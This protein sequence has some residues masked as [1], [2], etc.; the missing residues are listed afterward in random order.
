MS[1][2]PAGF[3]SAD[4]VFVPAANAYA[5]VDKG[6]VLQGS[7]DV[8]QDVF[9]FF[10]VLS[11][12]SETDVVTGWKT[13]DDPDGSHS[14]ASSNGIQTGYECIF[15][16]GNESSQGLKLNYDFFKIQL[17]L[18]SVDNLA[19]YLS[20]VEL[21]DGWFLDMAL[22]NDGKPVLYLRPPYVMT[23]SPHNY[24]TVRFRLYFYSSS[25]IGLS[26]VSF[27]SYP[28]VEFGDFVTSGLPSTVEGQEQIKNAINDQYDTNSGQQDAITGDV[29]TAISGLE[30]IGLFSFL[31]DF[32]KQF[33]GV[34]SSGDDS[35]ALT[36]PGFSIS[37]DGEQ[38]TVW[39][40]HTFDFAT[41]E[42]P[43]A[44]LLSALRLGTSVVVIGALISYLFGLYEHIFAGGEQY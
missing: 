29:N 1:G 34:F 23:V 4:A 22:S 11:L 43:F 17:N 8:A 42:G 33:V 9:Y 30:N 6:S 32:S 38:L 26:S 41:M 40:A 13:Y 7:G 25:A 21:P 44:V 16:I 36:L 5:S 19:Y 20:D 15:Q 10:N 27:V 39:E 12:A 35:T 18:S 28:S 2:L 37:V 14:V 3:C 24:Y 31:I